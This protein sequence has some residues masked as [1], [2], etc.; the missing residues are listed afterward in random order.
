MRWI[1]MTVLV[2]ATAT[3]G[4]PAPAAAQTVAIESASTGKCL[5]LPDGNTANG[6]RLLMFD[7]VGSSANQV[8]E[9]GARNSL[10]IFG[11]CVDAQGGQ[12]RQGDAVA[13]WDCNGGQNQVWTMGGDGQVRLGSTSLCLDVEGDNRGNGARLVV[14]G[15]GG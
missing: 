7:C 11:K 10:R 3:A 2:A 5:D 9:W 4:V 12:L 15:C 14:W 6:T 13:I 8:F 1:L